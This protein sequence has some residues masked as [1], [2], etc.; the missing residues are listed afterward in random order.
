MKDS[1]TKLVGVD[2][3]L[4]KM[5]SSRADSSSESTHQDSIQKFVRANFGIE[6]IMISCVFIQT[7]ELTLKGQK[8]IYTFKTYCTIGIKFRHSNFSIKEG[9]V[10]LVFPLF[11]QYCY[12]VILFF[13]VKM[14]GSIS[15]EMVEKIKRR[16]SLEF[17]L[18]GNQ[19]ALEFDHKTERERKSL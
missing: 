3:E 4:F 11:C 18:S 6:V 8:S 12:V 17:E 7:N 15:K 14:E 5:E 16:E 9:T 2:F 19:A 1:T 10:H 13:L